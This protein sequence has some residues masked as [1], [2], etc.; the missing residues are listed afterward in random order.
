MSERRKL[1]DHDILQLEVLRLRAQTTQQVATIAALEARF[2]VQQI[3]AEYE[4][5]ARRIAQSQAA[6]GWTLDMERWE[7]VAPEER[8]S[9]GH[10]IRSDR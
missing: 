1:A 9:N 5:T 10:D 4:A 3:L 2:A 8:V 6:D 7:W